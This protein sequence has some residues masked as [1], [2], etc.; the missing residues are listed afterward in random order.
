MPIK[1]YHPPNNTLWQGRQTVIPHE[2]FYQHVQLIDIEKHSENFSMDEE[3]KAIALIGFCCDAGVVRNQ[4]RPGA[5]AGPDII[6]KHLAKLAWHFGNKAIYDLGNV[7]C[8]DDELEEAQSQL[9]NVVEFAL[10]HNMLPIVLGGGHE[11]AWGHYQGLRKVYSKENINIVNFD[12]HFDLRDL[13]P[14]KKGSSGTPF[15]QIAKEC[16]AQQQAFNYTVLGLQES[17]NP[18]S[19]MEKAKML[20]VQ[21][22]LADAIDKLIENDS[23]LLPK[24]TE[25]IYLTFCLD[26]MSQSVAPGVSAPQANGLF[27]MQALALL[28]MILEQHKL[29]TFDIVE[30][31][32]NQDDDFKTARLASRIIYE[33]IKLY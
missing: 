16:E 13:L 3:K 19:L 29:L 22:Y 20:G 5:K 17:V 4:G 7:E 32:P 18:I 1:H 12:A 11:T 23:L 9:A 25:G 6:R 2:Y 31:A 15:W 26:V 21:Y 33:I 30:Y 27:P 10:K 28:K 24:P 8:Y 14:G